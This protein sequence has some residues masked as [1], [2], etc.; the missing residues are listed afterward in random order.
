MNDDGFGLPE[1]PPALNFPATAGTNVPTIAPMVFGEVEVQFNQVGAE[2]NAPPGVFD[3]AAGTPGGWSLQNNSDWFIGNNGDWDWVQFTIQSGGISN[4]L[5]IWNIDV[6]TNTYNPT[7]S[8]VPQRAGGLKTGDYGIVSGYADPSAQSLIMLAQ[9]SWVESGQPDAFILVAPDQFNLAKSWSQISG[10]VLGLGGGS[11]AVFT[12]TK[13]T[14]TLTTSNC[15]GD[16]SASSPICGS[17]PVLKP[18]VTVGQSWGSA[19][20]NNLTEQ[21]TATVTYPNANLA[22]TSWVE[23][24]CIPENVA[25]LSSYGETVSNGCGGTYECP[26]C[27]KA[28]PRCTA[29]GTVPC[30][31]AATCSWTCTP[32]NDCNP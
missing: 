15:V 13:V 11:E 24:T 18:N 29:R 25:C 12:D 10:S 28:A 23:A 2:S 17:L 30:L 22:D 31:H 32:I 8:L 3:A 6:T 14:T 7:C 19:E 20:G 27:E 1:A 5:C 26:P 21:G 16:T 9:F 4:R